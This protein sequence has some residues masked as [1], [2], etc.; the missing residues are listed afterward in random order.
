MGLVGPCTIID[1]PTYDASYV[2][3]YSDEFEAYKTVRSGL[4][5]LWQVKCRHRGKYELQIDWDM[6]YIPRM[7]PKRRG[8][9]QERSPRQENQPP[10]PS[11]MTEAFQR[12][13]LVMLAA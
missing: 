11:I 3:Q 7:A 1:S 9:P 8:H 13:L 2:R 6:Y 12:G 4:T 5:G 10:A